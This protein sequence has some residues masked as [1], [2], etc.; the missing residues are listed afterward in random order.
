VFQSLLSSNHHQQDQPKASRVHP[1]LPNPETSPKVPSIFA[2]LAP[3]ALVIIAVTFCLR[4]D[5]AF[6]VLFVIRSSLQWFV[7]IKLFVEHEASLKHQLAVV[8]T[9]VYA[10]AVFEWILLLLAF[11]EV[12]GVGVVGGDERDAGDCG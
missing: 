12:E 8:A 10:I 4:T 5:I 1:N 3:N 11:F 9:D 7:G 2:R 6:A